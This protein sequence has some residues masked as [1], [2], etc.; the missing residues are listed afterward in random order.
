MVVEEEE[1]DP[2]EED[3][4]EDE[5]DPEAQAQ[6]DTDTDPSGFGNML[7]EDLSLHLATF[8]VAPPARVIFRLHAIRLLHALLR[9][10]GQFIGVYR[11]S[12]VYCS[13]LVMSCFMRS[14][15]LDST[16][17]LLSYPITSLA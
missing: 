17:V 11:G 8:P 3:E 13:I 4:E 1:E 6:E 16:H 7:D 2:Q 15:A 14:G 12:R 9:N 10:R 5:E